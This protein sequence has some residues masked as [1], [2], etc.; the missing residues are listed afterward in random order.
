MKKLILRTLVLFVLTAVITSC[1]SDDEAMGRAFITTWEITTANETITIP[2]NT[3]AFTYNYSVDWGDDENSD[4]QTGNATHTYAT[5]GIYTIEITGAFPA[6]YFAGLRRNAIK[7][8]TIAQWGDIV[9]ESMRSSF[10]GCINLKGTATDTPNLS[11]VTNMTAMFL[12]AKAFNQDIS[13]WDVSNVTKMAFM[14]DNA[15]SFNQDVSGW[16]VSNVTD[17]RGMFI[18]AKAFNQDISSWNV[19]NVTDMAFMLASVAMFNQ[20]LSGW[21]ISNVTDMRSMFS[22]ASAFDQDLSGW[23]T[24]NVTICSNFDTGSALTAGN[25]PTMGTCC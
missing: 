17:M 6:I 4:N 13:G 5:P 3:N 22:D 8:Q 19:S 11:N 25:L 23:D 1:S 18:N 20:D 15:E 24:S 16:N 21:N 7:I 9:W 10:D 2:T 12:N 14:F